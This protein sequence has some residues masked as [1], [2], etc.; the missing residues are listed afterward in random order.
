VGAESVGKWRD[1][2][3][4]GMIFPAQQPELLPLPRRVSLSFPTYRYVIPMNDRM[5]RRVRARRLMEDRPKPRQ[6]KTAA[7]ARRA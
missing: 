3:R 6:Q 4:N 1:F 5:M 7:L 2:G